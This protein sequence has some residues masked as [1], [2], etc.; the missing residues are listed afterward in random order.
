MFIV[1]ALQSSETVQTDGVGSILASPVH[2]ACSSLQQVEGEGPS[3]ALS[4]PFLS[5]QSLPASTFPAAA[6]AVAPSLSLPPTDPDL[7]LDLVKVGGGNSIDDELELTLAVAENNKWSSVTAAEVEVGGESGVKVMG[8]R[9]RPLA[10][11]CSLSL[12][13]ITPSSDEEICDL[14][15]TRCGHP[16]PPHSHQQ[17]SATSISHHEETSLLAPP[18]PAP[19]RSVSPRKRRCSATE[20]CTREAGVRSWSGER[21]F[22]DFEKMQVSMLS[23][24]CL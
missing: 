11:A 15:A 4:L 1:T 6:P 13:T 5:H 20:G 14:F 8:G 2:A 19:A 17:R 9:K 16:Q 24:I 18:L 12:D 3:C 23:A 22:L 21:P 10:S 7:H